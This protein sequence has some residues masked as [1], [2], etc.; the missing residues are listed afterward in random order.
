MD[1]YKEPRYKL[2]ITEDPQFTPTQLATFLAE[3][4]QNSI[5][6]ADQASVYSA[7]ANVERQ[8]AVGIRDILQQIKND[9][10]RETLKTYTPDGRP[11]RMDPLR[12]YSEQALRDQL[13]IH[14]NQA[15]KFDVDATMFLSKAAQER[16]EVE[17][18]Q[19][20]L[21]KLTE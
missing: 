15:V 7:Q 10:S 12:T 2:E 19:T 11:R 14:K 4:L 3:A 18:L 13:K 6:H 9:P 8:K 17:R 5:L 16:S 21:R 1:E 20:E